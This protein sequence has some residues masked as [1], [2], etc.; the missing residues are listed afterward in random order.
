M[1]D[2]YLGIAKKVIS[3]ADII[4]LILDS[5][6]IQE[7]RNP[8]IES[9]VKAAGKPLIY[10]ITKSDLVSRDALNRINLNPSAFVSAKDHHGTLKLRNRIL[11][12]G[13]KVYKDKP[14]FLVGVLGYPNV[15]KSSLINA[16]KGRKSAKT[17]SESGYTK[18][19]KKIK[20]DKKIVF[21][22]T[23]GVIPHKEADK[24]KH[25]LIGAVDYNKMKDPDL[26]VMGLIEKYPG[27][28]EKHYGIPKSEDFE[29]L[30]EKIAEKKNLMGKGKE[31]DIKRA[32]RMI[33][34]DWQTGKIK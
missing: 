20:A 23:P 30:I 34:K 16:L 11:I 31:P 9:K 5:R 10:V 21:L 4:L 1:I 17:S 33:L 22:D 14:S 25:A 27:V 7:T 28:I 18:K 12:E 32:S 2:R 15:G 29:E 13:N 8:D 19:V 26:A 3:Q 6:M 24:V